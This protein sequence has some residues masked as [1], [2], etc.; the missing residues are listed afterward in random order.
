LV[1]EAK[2]VLTRS[3]AVADVATLGNL[4][5]ADLLEFAEVAL[6]GP[7]VA[8]GA[9]RDGR[10]ARPALARVV[11]CEVRKRNHHKGFGSR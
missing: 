11:A 4:E 8:P 2:A 7:P 3:V 1:V 5:Q 10:D 6:H 9:A